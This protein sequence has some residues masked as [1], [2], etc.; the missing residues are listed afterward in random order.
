MFIFFASFHV[1]YH[2]GV[3]FAHPD[4]DMIS[5]GN[6]LVPKNDLGKIIETIN[7]AGDMITVPP[8]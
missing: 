3:S 4:H 8:P 1:E 5:L 7:T 2:H 6:A